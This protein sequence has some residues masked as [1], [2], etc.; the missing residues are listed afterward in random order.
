MN[1]VLGFPSCNR[2]ASWRQIWRLISVSFHLVHTLQQDRLHI[3]TK[4]EKQ[5]ERD[6]SEKNQDKKLK[7]GE[8]GAVRNNDRD[9]MHEAGIGTS[10]GEDS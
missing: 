8:G 9:R 7:K 6:G 1:V 3:E 10:K 5:S 2:G 4:K